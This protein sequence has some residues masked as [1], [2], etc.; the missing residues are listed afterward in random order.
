MEQYLKAYVKYLQDNWPDWLSLAK[1]T[2]NNIKSET[3]KV[4]SFFANKGF[5]FCMGFKP[6]KPSSRNIREVNANAFAMQIE[7]IQEILQDNMLIV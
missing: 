4:S 5:H 1:F 3:T 2:S 7:E 6:A